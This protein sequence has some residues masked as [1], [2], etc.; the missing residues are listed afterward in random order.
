[1]EEKDDDGKNDNIN[2]WREFVFV[3]KRI[4]L[5]QKIFQDV[6]YLSGSMVFSVSFLSNK[7][8]QF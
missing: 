5:I 8:R 4:Y 3:D 1:M 6:R 2:D 7:L